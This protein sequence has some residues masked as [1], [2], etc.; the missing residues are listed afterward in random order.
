[1]EEI[2]IQIKSKILIVCI[3]FILIFAIGSAVAASD[4]DGIDAND[5]I[6][7]NV[8]TADDESNGGDSLAIEDNQDNRSVLEHQYTDKLKAD[9]VIYISPDGTGDGS[10]EDNPTT[11]STAWGNV[12]SGGTIGFLPGTY[13]N[14]KNQNIN[15]QITLKGIGDGVV[16]DAQETGRFFTV[17]SNNV[18]IDNMRFINGYI[19]GDGGALNWNG[20]NGYLTNCEFYNNWAYEDGS[21]TGGAVCWLKQKGN[22]INCTFD[23]NYV[24]GGSDGPD[25]GA[26]CFYANYMLVDNCIF[27]NNNATS[28]GG[29]CG[30]AIA[31]RYSYCTIK[32]SNFT[33]NNANWDGAVCLYGQHNDVINCIFINNTANKVYDGENGGGAIHFYDNYGSVFNSTFI[34]NTARTKNGGAIYFRTATGHS[35]NNLTLINNTA[36]SN[37]GAIYFANAISNLIFTNNVSL[38]NNPGVFYFKEYNNKANSYG[39]LFYIAGTVSSLT[40]KDSNFIRDSASQ[41]GNFYFNSAVSTLNVV[42]CNFTNSTAGGYG[43][44]VPLLRILVL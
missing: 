41:G 10:S 37:G 42:N 1:M 5:T 13:T 2:I 9:G 17:S 28:A 32:N 21:W 30:G 22:I 16:L 11:W 38:A 3:C 19:R 12:A 4:E 34:N 14:I 7:N 44:I 31:S 26:V 36:G 27:N 20:E 8:L 15:K 23:S 6:T 35:F 24:K 39:G 29:S 25:G 33:N 40:I 18:V 43:V